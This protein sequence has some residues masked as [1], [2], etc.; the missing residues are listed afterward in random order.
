VTQASRAS[1]VIVIEHSR[2][3]SGEATRS[4]A[5]EQEALAD[6][7]RGASVA[8]G[9][10]AVAESLGLCGRHGTSIVPPGGR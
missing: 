4:L 9:D 3:A 1:Q 10:A 6:V 8:I 7:M 2:V 5:R